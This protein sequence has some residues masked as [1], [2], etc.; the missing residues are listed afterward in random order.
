MTIPPLLRWLLTS[1]VVAVGTAW[2]A[3]LP[4]GFTHHGNFQRMMHSGDTD[5]QVALSA[6]PQQP[7]AWG[8][9]AMAGLSGELVQLDGRL[10]VSP[11][12][13][14]Q[15]RTQAPQP[16]AQAALFAAGR[17][18][19]WHDV[20]LPHDMDQAGLEAFVRSQAGGLGL[21]PDHPFVFR[22]E[23]NFPHLLWHVVTG[24]APAGAGP[25]AAGGHAGHRQHGGHANGRSDMHLFRQPGASGQLIGVYRG[26]LVFSAISDGTQS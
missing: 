8:V 6:L 7:G 1:V 9:G 10:L 2:A 3:G 25:A 24:A 22:V 15:G 5:G 26:L 13:D 16:G 20:T 17:V 14:A 18:Q 12:S 21:A 23:G 19:A 11:G 4:L